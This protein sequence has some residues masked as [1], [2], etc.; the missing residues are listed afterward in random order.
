MKKELTKKTQDVAGFLASL[1]N[2]E[3][4]IKVLLDQAKAA[5]SA[6]D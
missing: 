5:K 2:A 3:A 1:N 4:K 6:Q